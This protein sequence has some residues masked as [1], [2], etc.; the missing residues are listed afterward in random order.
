MALPARDLRQILSDWLASGARRRRMAVVL[1]LAGL[2]LAMTAVALRAPEGLGGEAVA[3]VLLPLLAFAIP[4]AVAMILLDASGN[5]LALR[6]PVTGLAGRHEFSRALERRLTGQG[7]TGALL[8][9]IDRFKLIEEAHDRAEVE[10]LLRRSAARLR[11]ALREDDVV[12]RLDG[13][14]FGITPAP[15]SRL[16]LESAIA[17]AGRLQRALGRA[18]K[19]GSGNVYLSASIGIALS[20]RTDSADAAVLLQAANAALIEAQR[21]GP[22]AIRSYS[23]AMKSRIASRNGLTFEV[24]DALETGQI[25]AYFQ[26][27]ITAKGRVIS[28]VEALARWRHPTRGL[29][30]PAEFLPALEQAGLMHRLGEEMLTQSLDALVEWDA[31]GLVLPHI[32]VNFS[33]AEL[34]DP[35]LI[36]RTA[37]ELDSRNLPAQRLVV[38]V[39]ETVVAGRAEDTVMRNLAGLARLGCCIDLDDF[40]TGHASITAIRRFSIQRIKIDRSFISGIDQEFEKQ[41]MVGAILTIAGQLGLET[42]AEGVESE[43][44]MEILSTLGCGHLQGF[45]IARPMPKDETATWLRS[46]SLPAAQPA[47]LPRRAS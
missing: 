9:E 46:A 17:L 18:M 32:A 39:L 13:P 26:P 16:D 3:S 19:I 1:F 2:A 7:E 10:D 25:R 27:Q 38:E 29:I 30:S 31:A 36:D 22:G 24:A 44:E 28:G 14:S 42:L 6:D 12:A 40:G 20:S 15:G 11:A 8:V 43:E 47:R 23:E 34:N 4:A 37:F 41:T 35:Q 33:A 21:A 5:V 45:G